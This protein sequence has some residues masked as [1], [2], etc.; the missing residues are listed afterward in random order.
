M[1]ARGRSKD[2]GPYVHDHMVRQ[3]L[4]RHG[5]AITAEAPEAQAEDRDPYGG[6]GPYAHD[7]VVRQ[8]L[9]RHGIAITAD[10]GAR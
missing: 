9:R 3:A 2:W 8:A 4:R 5:I 10:G 6:Y 1:K 7:H